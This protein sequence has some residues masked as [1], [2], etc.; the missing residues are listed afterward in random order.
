MHCHRN[1]AYAVLSV[2]RDGRARLKG[3][4]VA[5]KRTSLDWF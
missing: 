1:L 2:G 4:I 5:G 3:L